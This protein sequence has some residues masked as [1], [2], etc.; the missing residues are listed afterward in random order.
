MKVVWTRPACSDL[1]SIRDSIARD[2]EHYAARY[3]GQI[4]ASVDR[5]RKFPELGEVILQDRK[6]VV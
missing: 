4:L 5:L 1:E 2:S 6:S 3:I